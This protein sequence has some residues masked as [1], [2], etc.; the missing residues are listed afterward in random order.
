MLN[1]LSDEKI[2]FAG[3]AFKNLGKITLCKGN[4][5]TTEDL[6]YIDVLLIRSG[7]RVDPGLIE[8]TP[9]RFIA[10]ATVGTDHVNEAFLAQK[11]I[12]FYHAPGCNAESVVEYVIAALLSLASR[13]GGALRGKTIGIIGAGNI[14]GRLARRLPALGIKVIVNDPLLYDAKAAKKA[15]FPV[16]TLEELLQTADIVTVHTPLTREGAHATYHLLNKRRLKQMQAGAWLI[17]ASRGPVVNNADLKQVLHAGHLGAVV[18]DVW[19]GEPVVDTELMALVDIATPHIAGHS[20]EGKV[21]GT[22]QIYQ[23]YTQHYGLDDRWDPQS[24]LAPAAEDHLQLKWPAGGIETEAGLRSLVQQMYDI[25]ADDASFRRSIALPE[26]ERGALFLKLRKDYPRRRTFALHKLNPAV[27]LRE[28]EKSV[29]RYGLG[30]DV[31]EP[32][33]V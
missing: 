10:S 2:L 26:D 17:N 27:A 3:E 5:L 11:G 24:I 1:I 25:E 22:I 12:P 19:E 15:P 20:Y 13:K 14:G 8:G 32:R 18:L 29:L 4:R 31:D 23:A 28:K 9:V 30:I 16:V 7:T 33:A 6:K 21:N